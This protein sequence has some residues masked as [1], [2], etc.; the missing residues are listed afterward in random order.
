MHAVVHMGSGGMSLKMGRVSWWLGVGG[1]WFKLGQK[2]HCELAGLAGDG[3]NERGVAASEA[4][5]EWFERYSMLVVHKAHAEKTNRW[6]ARRPQS[7]R[8]WAT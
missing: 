6:R 7:G 2:V 4:A 3:R 5:A 8:G 1:L